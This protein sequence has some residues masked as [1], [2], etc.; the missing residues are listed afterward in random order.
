MPE[1]MVYCKIEIVLYWSESCMEMQTII[2]TF[3]PLKRIVK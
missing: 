2:L 1:I 3:C